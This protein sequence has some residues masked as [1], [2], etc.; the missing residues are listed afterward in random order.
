MGN[1]ELKPEKTVSY[2]IGLKQALTQNLTIDITGY[3]KDI[4]DLIGQ[5]TLTNIYGGRYWRFINRDYANVRGVTVA[6]EMLQQ[7]GGIGFS[8][9]Y[10]YQ[11]ATGNASDPLDESKN[12]ETDPPIQSEKKR[13]PLNW[14][15]THSL[16][17]TATTTQRGYHL[18]LI[19]KLGS[20]TPYTRESP[21][22]N[23]RILNGEQKPMTMTI[24]LNL[25][26]DLIYRNFTMSLFLKVTNLFDRKNNQE[27]YASSG[28]ADYDY[29]MRYA[30]YRG[31]GT[32][33]EWYIQ[34]NYYREVRKVVLGCSFL[35]D[36]GNQ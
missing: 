35:F 5:V 36:R 24:D 15:Q 31:Y 11:S 9:D 13:R 27:V 1:A 34:P 22:F 28:S 12:Q 16:N 30:N 29:S 20:G 19:G 2:E 25:T 18:S 17:L 4:R 6:L 21:F 14:D 7:P 33:E 8:L 26:K 32:K 10:T 23:N 3:N